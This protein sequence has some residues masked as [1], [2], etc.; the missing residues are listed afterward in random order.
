MKKQV[1]LIVFAMTVIGL[2]IYA[3]INIG[4]ITEANKTAKINRQILPYFTFYNTDSVLTNNRI[5]AKDV[6]VCIFYFNVDF[7]HCHYE[8]KE[9][10]KNITLFKNAQIIMISSNTLAQIKRFIA[11]HKLNYPNVIF[12]QDPKYEFAEWF[13]NASIPSVYIYNTKRQ[14]VKEYHGETNIEYITKYL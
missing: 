12:L 10:S 5:I 4:N 8:A 1:I 11:Q 14:L 3:I 13:G 9:I 6:S 2:T 7:E